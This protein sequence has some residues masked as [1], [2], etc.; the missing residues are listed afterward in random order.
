MHATACFNGRRLVNTIIFY[1]K[2]CG[3]WTKRRKVRLGKTEGK[4]GPECVDGCF[5]FP[6]FNLTRSKFLVQ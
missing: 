4:E 6:R 2:I 3:K 5:R 1:A